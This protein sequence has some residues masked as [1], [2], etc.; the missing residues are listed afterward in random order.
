MRHVACRG[1]HRACRATGR[2][3]G[4]V[5][6]ARRRREIDAQMRRIETQLG[7]DLS[8][9]EF[10]WKGCAGSSL[11]A[12]PWRR[13]RGRPDS[14]KRWTSSTA[15]WRQ[16]FRPGSSRHFVAVTARLAHA[17]TTWTSNSKNSAM[18]CA[19]W[20]RTR[21]NPSQAVSKNPADLPPDFPGFPDIAALKPRTRV[22]SSGRRAKREPKI[23]LRTWKAS[24]S[25]RR[26]PAA[27]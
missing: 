3:A 7:Q 21:Q 19:K 13:S 5:R 27:S 17:F 16:A 9:L 2:G 24:S 4:A 26:P 1:S 10:S 18:N 15:L 25:V 12:A 22:S 23:S 20:V 6:R 14:R 8:D 11:P